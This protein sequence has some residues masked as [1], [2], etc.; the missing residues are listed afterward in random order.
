MPFVCFFDVGMGSNLLLTNSCLPCSTCFLKPLPAD[1]FPIP[2]HETFNNRLDPCFRTIP[3]F[4]TEN[5]RMRFNVQGRG[6][7]VYRIAS[8]ATSGWAPQS[9]AIR[10]ASKSSCP[11]RLRNGKEWLA[12]QIKSTGQVLNSRSCKSQ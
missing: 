7:Q 4:F 5:S 2:A 12:P 3:H 10:T 9:S 11:N 8:P 1:Y 6:V